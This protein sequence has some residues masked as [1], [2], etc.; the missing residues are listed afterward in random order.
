M[1]NTFW[2]S[3]ETISTYSFHFLS[4][5]ILSHILSPSDYGIFGMMGIFIALGNM[6]VDSGMG[7]ALVRKREAT[8]TDFSTLFCFNLCISI[9]IYAFI[10]FI[11]GSV[12]SFYHV[13]ALERCL[14]VYGIFIIINA[15][16]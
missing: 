14:Q 6:L 8:N 7:G 12:A 3:L 16:I 2:V 15:F 11:S 4:L 1:K 5:V 10:F 13:E 9:I